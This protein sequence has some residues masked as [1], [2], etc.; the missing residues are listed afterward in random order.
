MLKEIE[1]SNLVFDTEL[2]KIA[3]RTVTNKLHYV[4]FVNAVEKSL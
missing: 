3:Y 2:N 1:N 4:C